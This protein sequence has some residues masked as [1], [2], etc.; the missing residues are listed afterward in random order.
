MRENRQA[1]GGRSRARNPEKSRLLCCQHRDGKPPKVPNMH[2][3]SQGAM[4]PE[5]ARNPSRRPHSP[6]TTFSGPWQGSDPTGLLRPAMASYGRIWLVMPP[7]LPPFL[8]T[9]AGEPAS[10]RGPQAT[11]GGESATGAKRR[12]DGG[13]VPSPA[14]F[15][16]EGRQAI[17]E[18]PG[19]A[20]WNSRQKRE[21]A[22]SGG[23]MAGFCAEFVHRLRPSDRLFP[24]F[25]K[26]LSCL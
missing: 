16:G 13:D 2:T 19:S 6:A 20:G 14:D 18:G 5:R 26:F 8:Q 15:R 23:V 9:S 12:E 1:A 17:P 25:L 7:P 3:V 4:D 22:P 21:N 24:E 10:G 11:R